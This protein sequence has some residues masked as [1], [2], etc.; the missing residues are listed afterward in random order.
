MMS[1][2]H[3]NI[4]VYGKV[5]GVF[6]RASAKQI[7]EQL[8][9]KGTVKNEADGNVS[10]EAEGAEQAIAKFV[11]WCKKGPPAAKVTKVEV[12]EGRV[13]GY[14]GFEIIR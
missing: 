2:I 9:I 6:F 10:I 8:N 1:L 11:T 14:E 7:A 4:R 12:S 13:A 3:K 5:Q